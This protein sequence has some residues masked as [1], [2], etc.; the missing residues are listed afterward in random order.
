MGSM[1]LEFIFSD[2]IAFVRFTFVVIVLI[3]VVSD[4]GT[5]VVDSSLS[6]FSLARASVVVIGN[7]QV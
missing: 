4:R 2:A 3:I 5:Y 6:P 7:V 1:G